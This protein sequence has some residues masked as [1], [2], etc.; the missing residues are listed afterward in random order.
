[1]AMMA[2]LMTA[3]VIEQKAF[4]FWPCH[5]VS[6]H[7]CDHPFFLEGGDFYVQTLVSVEMDSQ[8]VAVK[9]DVDDVVVVVVVACIE[10]VVFVVIEVAAVAVEAFDTAETVV[11]VSVTPF[12]IAVE[13][14]VVVSIA[15][16]GKTVAGDL[17]KI[18]AVDVVKLKGV[19][20]VET[21]A[22]ADQY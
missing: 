7:E 18:V 9:L 8:E 12:V 17:G 3:A 16:L 19:P 22:D 6:L 14:F 20:L 15:A 2:P 5:C 13:T 1:M 11:V 10:E 4:Y 21:V